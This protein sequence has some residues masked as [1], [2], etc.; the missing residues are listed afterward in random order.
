MIYALAGALA[1]QEHVERVV[2]VDRGRVAASGPHETLLHASPMYRQ[3]VET[4]LIAV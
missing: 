3:L 1:V 2:L 4:Q